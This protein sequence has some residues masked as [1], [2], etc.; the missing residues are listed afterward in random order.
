M[1]TIQFLNKRRNYSGLT[2]FLLGKLKNL[3][4]S[5]G[6]KKIPPVSTEMNTSAAWLLISLL[7]DDSG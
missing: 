3:L 4:E 6:R 7:N 2:E 1:K 5:M